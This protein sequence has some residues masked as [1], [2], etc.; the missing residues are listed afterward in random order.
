MFRIDDNCGGDNRSAFATAAVGF[1]QEME[2]FTSLHYAI[3][4]TYYHPSTRERFNC[5]R[6]G[7]L[8]E[9]ENSWGLQLAFAGRNTLHRG[10]ARASCRRRERRCSTNEVR[11]N[12]HD[13]V[14]PSDSSHGRGHR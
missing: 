7:G 10:M 12:D 11:T 8:R 4:A 5:R 2:L 14:D 9:R 13:Y 1:E 6:L 3:C